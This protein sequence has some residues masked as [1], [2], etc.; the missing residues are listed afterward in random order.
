MIEAINQA[1]Q[2][3]WGWMG[4]M[5]WQASLLIIIVGL[6]D[7]LL[8]RWAW[9]Q[10]R[11][12]LWALVLLKLLIPPSWGLPISL[13]SHWGGAAQTRIEERLGLSLPAETDVK[14]PGV[15]LHSADRIA[16]L[17]PQGA[18]GQKAGQAISQPLASSSPPTPRPKLGWKAAAMAGWI[19]GVGLF[20]GLLARRIARLRRWHKNQ[21]ERKTIPVW[22]Y[23]LLVATAKRLKLGRL[24]AIV[25]SD[26]ANAPA[27][28]GLFHPVL[29][30]PA[31]YLE[32]LSREDAGHVLLH[33]LAHLKRGDLWLQGLGLALQIVYWFNPLLIWMR[34]QMKHGGEICCDLTIAHLLKEDT[35]KYRKT[36]LNTARV[37][38][39]ETAVPGMGLLG[40]FEDPFRIVVRLKWL[41]KKTW[42]NG[43]LMTAVVA[44]AM[45]VMTATV[46]PMGR[47]PRAGSVL[48]SDDRAAV[49]QPAK[50]AVLESQAKEALP[51]PSKVSSAGA[52]FDFKVCDAEAFQAVMLTITGPV[53]ELFVGAKKLQDWIQRSGIA[54]TGPLF[55][56]QLSNLRVEKPEYQT[57]WGVG[58]PVRDGTPASPP[59]EIKKY[60]AKL[61]TYLTI[62]EAVDED[63]LNQQ[64]SQ[65]L[66]DH[67]YRI[68]GGAMVFCPD[69]IYGRGWGR[70]V[71]EVR[72]VIQRMKGDLPDK[73]IEIFTQWAEARVAAVLPVQGSYDQE[74]EALAK[75][76]A[77]LKDVG[78]TSPG[79]P[80]F[81][82]FNDEAI[83]PDKELLWEVGFPVPKGVAVR[84]PFEIKNLPEGLEAYAELECTKEDLLKYCFAYAL[85]LQ[86]RGFFGIG[87]PMITLKSGEVHG[88]AVR[89]VRIPV[90]RRRPNRAN[91][92]VFQ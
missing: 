47:T 71:W 74:P 5:L 73:E 84:A 68:A 52:A 89:E 22:Y 53:E 31:R 49:R 51:K 13:V 63:E 78:L 48:R 66:W 23:E 69:R 41:E 90:R 59:F 15:S 83:F 21:V 39:T 6:I 8:R 32:S 20:V 77:Y 91:L 28:Y 29:L 50:E 57:S 65:W 45:L 46:L 16:S 17:Q 80:F 27:V 36:L 10:L 58:Y 76:E 86:G 85:K 55:I 18:P 40:V 67:K 3:W 7:V 35:A 54:P 82:Y 37:L 56:Q 1:A 43:R 87:Y 64:W 2:F 34:K 60:P 4:A 44:L 9:P 38:L 33:E 14:R 11:Y 70:P 42:R 25:F 62:T 75:L 92:P 24:P 61:V 81:R 12:A 26:E 72:S 30:L 19:L 79:K 88:K